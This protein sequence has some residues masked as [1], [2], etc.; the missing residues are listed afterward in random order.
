MMRAFAYLSLALFSGTTFAQSTATATAFEI[1]D[2]HASTRGGNPYMSGG[3]LRGDRF[4][5]RNASMLDLI[6]TAYGID[7]RTRIG[8]DDN[9][10]IVDGPNW[11]DTDRFD[12]VAKAPPDTSPGAVK[13]MLQTLLADRFKLVVHS[14]NRPLPA[15]VLS[16][17]SKGKPKLKDADPSGAPGCRSVPQD[18]ANFL[19]SCRNITME[20][21]VP[22]LRAISYVMNSPVVDSTGLKGAFDFDIKW[23]G[24]PDPVSVFDAIDEQLGLKLEPNKAPMPV[25]VVDSV[26]RKPT[27]NPPG[28]ATALPPPPAEF[29]VAD[30]KLSMPGANPRNRLQPGGRLDVQAFTLKMLINLA[31]NINNDEMLAG[32]PK[33]LDST[34][35]DIIAKAPAGVPE[36]DFDDARLMMRALLASRFKLAT[37]TEGRPVTAYKLVAVKPKLQRADPKSRSGC[38]E[39]PGADGKDPRVASPWLARLVTCQNISMAQFAEQLPSRAVDYLR[40]QVVDATGIKGEF[41]FTL[42]FS[43]AGLLQPGQPAQPGVAAVSDP[44]GTVSLFDALNKQLGL[45]LETEKRPMRVLVIDHVEEKPTDN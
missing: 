6:R 12:V 7:D 15:F 19:F 32:A 42:S 44:N 4:V 22:A 26:N 34:R 38:K 11:L 20:A 3:V 40:S 29:E 21:F 28:V 30:I 18:G 17:A 8:A 35:F 13:L 33:Y 27:A 36:I 31:W 43:P 2:V 14:D 1:A 9:S 41:D 16:V 39:G 10:K 24:P 37:H 5:I 23:K 45:K 25:I